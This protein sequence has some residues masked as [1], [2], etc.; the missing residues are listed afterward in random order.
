MFATKPSLPPVPEVPEEKSSQS[1]EQFLTSIGLEKYAKAFNDLGY[2]DLEFLRTKSKT[3][4][5]KLLTTKLKMLVGHAEKFAFHLLKATESQ[6][7][8][9]DTSSNNNN[10]HYISFIVDRSGS[11][12]TMG[13]E[14][15][16]GFNKFLE[17][18]QNA[19]K[20]SGEAW[21]T[22]TTF[23]D[24]VELVYDS[25]KLQDVPA[26]K[27]GGPFHPRGMTAL[28]DAIGDT[29]TL[30][31]QKS[32]AL[33]CGEVTVV[34]LTDGQ[35]N[36]SKRWTKEKLREKI[37]TMETKFGWEFIF[38][39]ANQDAIQ[40]GSTFGIKK[41]KAMTYGANQGGMQCAFLSVAQ[42]YHS[43]RA[44][45]KKMDFVCSQRMASAKGSV[46]LMPNLATR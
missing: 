20:S 11:M 17:E 43:K 27:P 28:L 5:E 4:L 3:E 25:L 36:C 30:T 9:Q 15:V 33:N 38:L 10:N 35:E 8:Q 19:K 31:E 40:V 7:P 41:G 34:I 13:D 1:V 44:H 14:T 12:S 24:T 6:S 32:K 29:I 22:L 39:A 23:D 42:N 16:S 37:K 21:L 26:V 45:R 46:K 2:D 18:Q